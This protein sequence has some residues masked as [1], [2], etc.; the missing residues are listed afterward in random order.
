M[1]FNLKKTRGRS[2]YRF[3]RRS[4]GN[5]RGTKDHSF[6]SYPGV[7]CPGAR[8]DANGAIAIMTAIM[9]PVIIG[10][11]ALLVDAGYWYGTS[12][13]LQNGADAG[14]IAGARTLPYSASYNSAYVQ[15]VVDGAVQQASNGV[16]GML[17]PTFNITGTGSS[18]SI[19]VTATAPQA[20]FLSSIFGHQPSE[21]TASSTASINTNMQ[22]CVLA[23]GQS[24]SDGILVN[25]T[26]STLDSPNCALYSSN[27]VQNKGAISTP[28]VAAV[29][30]IT[31]TYSPSSIQMPGSN[32]LPN[33]YANVSIPLTPQAC[34]VAGECPTS[35][36]SGS[37][38]VLQP[39]TYT[40]GLNIGS[41]AVAFFQPG[42]YYIQGG[43]L[44]FGGT[45]SVSGTGVTFVFIPDTNGSVGTIDWSGNSSSVALTGP[46]NGIFDGL[47][48]YQAAPATLT[49]TGCAC[50]Y[51][52]GNSSY[53]LSGGIDLQ[54]GTGIEFSGN[55]TS[56]PTVNT[57]ANVGI[58]IAAEYV[59]VA[60]HATVNT[61]DPYGNG[62]YVGGNPYLSK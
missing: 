23:L 54:A 15:N 11:G 55:S 61:G 57:S 10:F 35:V 3:H 25:D 49:T 45:A 42:I 39:G 19:T 50:A 8:M 22:A 20:I 37:D 24:A 48:I 27:W 6:W 5:P 51:I 56:G 47:L 26:A 40:G 38:I 36:P 28:A 53:N 34:A 52:S 31:G 13:L 59:T 7:S 17:S 41:N 33:P 18:R 60:G 44:S 1:M 32:P 30:S 62:A 29:G 43:N 12:A 21:I 4:P 16:S 14:A 46:A 58:D 9:L 2:F